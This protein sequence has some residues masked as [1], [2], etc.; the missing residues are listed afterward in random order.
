MAL[1]S[2]AAPILGALGAQTDLVIVPLPTTPEGEQFLFSVG[3]ELGGG[4]SATYYK[5]TGGETNDAFELRLRLGS[6]VRGRLRQNQD[7]SL[8]GGLRIRHELD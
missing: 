5:G 3:K 1:R 7:G 6:K 4:L 8:S 2:A